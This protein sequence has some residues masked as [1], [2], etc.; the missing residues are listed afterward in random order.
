MDDKGFF[1][2]LQNQITGLKIECP[3]A[4]QITELMSSPEDYGSYPNH[5]GI[6]LNWWSTLSKEDP[7]YKSGIIDLYF[8][9]KGSCI[10]GYK[11][12]SKEGWN[13]LKVRDYHDASNVLITSIHGPSY[14]FNTHNMVPVAIALKFVQ[15]FC[16]T[17]QII[18]NDGL[19]E[20]WKAS[21]GTEELS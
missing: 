18:I 16:D 8:D 12:Y 9:H 13:I 1:L 20:I 17:G 6:D 10:L 5:E 4:R 2:V 11:D 7:N 19:W 14:V 3:S 15:E 21:N